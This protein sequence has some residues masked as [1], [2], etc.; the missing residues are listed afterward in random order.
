MGWL[1]VTSFSMEEERMDNKKKN[2]W[3]QLQGLFPVTMLF[4]LFLNLTWFPLP[5][6]SV[7]SDWS[8][9][10]SKQQ[11]VYHS[12]SVTYGS[13]PRIYMFLPLQ[14]LPSKSLSCRPPAP[15]PFDIWP[16]LHGKLKSHLWLSVPWL[17]SQRD[18]ILSTAKTSI[19]FQGSSSFKLFST[20]HFSYMS[21]ISVYHPDCGL[22]CNNGKGTSHV[23]VPSDS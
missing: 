11:S 5:W 12:E 16:I 7:L 22:S 15:P 23:Y 20:Q 18:L 4:D 2:P 8:Q 10:P 1:G 13:L 21:Q 3:W 6:S 17:L 9:H 19:V 14:L